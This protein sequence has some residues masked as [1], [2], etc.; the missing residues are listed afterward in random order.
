MIRPPGMDGVAFSERADGDLRADDEARSAFA[1]HLGIEPEWAVVHQVHGSDVVLVDVPGQAGEADAIW[2]TTPGLPVAVFTADC[3][4]VVLEGDVA[5]GVAHAGWRGA[6]AGVVAEL[7]SHMADA[8]HPPRRAAIGP[9]IG[10]CC[11]EVGTDVASSFEGHLSDT[12]WGTP[13]VDLGGALGR[14]LDGLD[15]WAANAC[16]KHEARWFSHRRNAAPERMA[17]VGWL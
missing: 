12:S 17:A 2:T 9:G 6:R 13:S 14:Q 5:V 10:P 8:G 7:A 16:T 1:R 15:V 4:G 11:F 3:F